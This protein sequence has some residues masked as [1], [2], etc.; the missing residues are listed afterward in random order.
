MTDLPEAQRR[1]PAGKLRARGAGIPFDGEP[2]AWNAITDVPGVEVGYCTLI[3]G[4]GPLVVGTGPIRTGVTAI[5][6]LGLARGASAV[7]A[8][9]SSLNGYG[10]M[11]AFPWVD[12][13]GRCEGPIT[14]TNTHSVGV[15]RDATIKWLVARPTARDRDDAQ[16]WLPVA[17]ET[18]D[19]ELNDINGHHVRDEHVIR[20]IE[21]A[22]GGRIEE[23][24]VGGG[25]GMRCYQFKAGS[26]TASRA[27]D[28]AGERYHVGAFVQANFGRRYMC[29]VAG[30]P[31]GRHFPPPE[32]Q[33][34]TQ[35]TGSIIVIVAT[36]APLLPHQLRRVARRP[37]LA[38][39]RSGGVSAHYSGDL[40]L[41]F[42]TRN[43][44]AVQEARRVTRLDYLPDQLLTPIFEATIQAT[45]E[46][47]VNSFVGTAAMR[48][49]D[50]HLIE[51][52]PVER[53]REILRHHGRLVF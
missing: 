26:G 30:I 49:K 45:D 3:E 2:G 50:D 27:L 16:F 24:S 44:E 46:A 31:L 32:E 15:A 6:P 17:A 52:F 37:A 1:T 11:T 53:A 51:A 35:E 5:L 22:R 36:D 28:I 33:R 10:E 25:T 47:I 23:G 18:Y 8:G 13:A 12:E 19:G 38:M 4:D 34:A 39:A 21:S 14:L 48:G 20:A 43:A 9:V 29:T 7:W 40:F 42:T 41:A